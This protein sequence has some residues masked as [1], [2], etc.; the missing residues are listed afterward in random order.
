[1]RFAFDIAICVLW[2]VAWTAAIASWIKTRDGY[3]MAL[4]TCAATIVVPCIVAVVAFFVWT[5]PGDVD[6]AVGERIAEGFRGLGWGIVAVVPIAL[7]VSL[8]VLFRAR[9]EFGTRGSEFD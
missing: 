1:M 9:I 6:D 7:V 8:A 4:M 5:D 2:F 3:R